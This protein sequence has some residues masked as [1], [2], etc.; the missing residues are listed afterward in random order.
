MASFLG[1]DP[2]TTYPADIRAEELPVAL[3]AFQRISSVQA[4]FVFGK[5]GDEVS[6]GDLVV[7]D[8]RTTGQNEILPATIA[9]LNNRQGCI[10]GV[11]QVALADNAYG[12]IMV[13][14]RGVVDADANCPANTVILATTNGGRVGISRANAAQQLH[15]IQL[16]TARGS[17]A[18][19]APCIFHHIFI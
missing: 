19:T 4:D 8:N 13:R 2:T 1:V 18:G 14:G 16:T 10:I 12:W 9:R 17:S 5:A 3:G 15:N 7:L 11:S 6:V